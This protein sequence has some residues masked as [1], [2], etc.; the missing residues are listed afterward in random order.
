[1]FCQQVAS[2]IT[3]TRPL[4]VKRER[5]VRAKRRKKW[6]HICNVNIETIK[7]WEDGAGM[8]CPHPVTLEMT[9]GAAP[10]KVENQHDHQGYTS[11][12]SEK[13]CQKMKDLT[14]GL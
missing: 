14:L 6:R 2:K 3:S 10:G 4:A 12:L 9:T 5:A 1:M 8:M 11:Q 7:I 13:Y